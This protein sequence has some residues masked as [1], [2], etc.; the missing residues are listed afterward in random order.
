MIH[1]KLV[2][3]LEVR[4]CAEARNVI[5]I[6]LKSVVQGLVAVAAEMMKRTNS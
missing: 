3:G 1:Q 6:I 4:I 5:N 2:T